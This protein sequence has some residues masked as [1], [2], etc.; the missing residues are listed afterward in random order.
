VDKLWLNDF[1]DLRVRP[2]RQKNG[3]FAQAFCLQSAAQPSQL[4]KIVGS[5][6]VTADAP[7]FHALP[8]PAHALKKA[9]S[10]HQTLFVDEA[11]QKF[12]HH[13]AY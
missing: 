2:W 13:C 7:F 4:P 5:G 6:R 1:V 11:H 3:A 8:C 9:H 12:F 10:S